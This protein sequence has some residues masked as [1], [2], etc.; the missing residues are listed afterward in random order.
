MTSSHHCHMLDDNMNAHAD[1]RGAM[2]AKGLAANGAKVYL[3]G[4]RKDVLDSLATSL[5]E[6]KG[7][8]IPCVQ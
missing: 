1:N 5:G 7:K 2:I 4:R 3:C 8:V 6:S